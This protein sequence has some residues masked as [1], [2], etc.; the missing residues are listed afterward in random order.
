MNIILNLF[1]GG[2]SRALTMSYDDGQVHDLR[3][4][5]LFDDNG[6]KG[7]FH[8]NSS[9][10]N[11]PGFLAEENLRGELK[12]HEISV[13]TKTHPFLTKIPDSIIISECMEDKA[14]LEHAVQV[15][16]RGMSY[17]YGQYTNHVI[18]ILRACG[19]EYSR[20]VNATNNF[21]IP[22]NFME[23][24]PTTHHGGNLDTLWE[25]FINRNPDKMLLFY[26]WGHSY[27]FHN[28]D[29]WEVIEH[30]CEIAG[31]HKD[32]WYATNVQIY[33]YVSAVHSLI[34]SADST[35][36]QNPTATDVWLTI[37]HKPV[38]IKAGSTYIATE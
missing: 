1:P 35:M 28:Q 12:N 11:K 23:W 24:H 38:C 14:F 21:E 34:F 36:I 9:N 5:K 3:L 27:E 32:I 17:P 2:V 26:L 31:G 25:Q 7:T 10:I 4:A 20:T 13:H 29:N 37:N 33:S 18:D 8:L 22:D 30:F 15:P 16:I 19:M 6:I